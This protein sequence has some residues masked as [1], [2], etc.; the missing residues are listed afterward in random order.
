MITEGEGKEKYRF[1]TLQIHAG[2]SVDPTTNAIVPPIVANS[3]FV[4]KSSDHAANLFGLKEDGFI[5]SRISNPTNA[6]FEKRIAALEGGVAATVTASG[7]AAEFLTILTL[8]SAGDNI[9]SSASLYGGTFNMFKHLL[10]KLGIEVRFIKNDDLSE[11]E[12]LI[13]AATKAFYVESIGNPKFDI[14]DFQALSAV[15]KKHGVPLVVDNTFGMGGFLFK[16]IDHGADIV[17]HSATKWIGGHGN[18]IGGVV[19]DAGSFNFANGRFPSFTES[20]PAYHGLKFWEAFGPSTPSKVNM[21]FT[22][23]LRCE[24]MRD[25]GAC[26]NPF[27]SFLLLSGLE[28]LSLRAERHVQNASA[29]AEW[30]LE[31]PQVAWVSYPGLKSHPS[32]LLALRYMKRGAGSVLSFGIV[33]G[34]EAGC[35]FIDSVKLAC[36]LANVGDARTLVIQPAFTTHQQLSDEEQLASGVTKDLIRVSVGIEH[37][38]DIKNDFK[39]ALLKSQ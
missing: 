4:F 32:H 8:A 34:L 9:V 21:S 6:A 17:V 27:G 24:Y 37:I 28:T 18:T 7:Q 14:P 10:P 35:R 2:N 25:I 23:K 36:H 26:Q 30:L 31:Q 15:A 33:G 11:F 38:E 16:P 1:E 3:S 12:K 39:Q 19:V 5:Y 29:L 20:S 13:D 22:A